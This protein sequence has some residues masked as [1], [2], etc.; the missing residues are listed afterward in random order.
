MGG[1]FRTTFT[2]TLYLQVEIWLKKMRQLL[3]F[4]VDKFE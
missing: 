2:P 3:L 1:V 4:S